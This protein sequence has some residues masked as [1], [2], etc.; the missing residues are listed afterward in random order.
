MPDLDAR[1]ILFLFG[2]APGGRSVAFLAVT[3]AL[4]LFVTLTLLLALSFLATLALIPLTLLALP[5]LILLRLDRPALLQPQEDRPPILRP[6]RRAVLGHPGCGR[7]LGAFARVQHE[8]LGVLAVQ[9]AP[10][11]HDVRGVLVLLVAVGLEDHQVGR[12]VAPAQ[13]PVGRLV[14]VQLP[15]A[16]GDGIVELH[17]VVDLVVRVDRHG[18]QVSLVLPRHLIDVAVADRGTRR[19]VPHQHVHA[20]ALLALGLVEPKRQKEPVV[21]E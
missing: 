17:A 3:L 16:A 19:H 1:R 12:L 9:I 20:V 6:A 18:Q 5:L 11:Q 8:G 7:H 4:S 15:H 2:A 13:V 10:G 21:R 14:G